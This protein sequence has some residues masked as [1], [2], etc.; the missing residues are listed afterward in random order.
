MFGMDKKVIRLIDAR[1]VIKKE[2]GEIVLRE[3]G[4][5]MGIGYVHGGY[6]SIKIK[7]DHPMF[8]SSVDSGACL[9]EHNYF[10]GEVQVGW[11]PRQ[12]NQRPK[13]Y[14]KNMS[15]YEKIRD[16]YVNSFE[17]LLPERYCRES[18]FEKALENRS[19]ISEWIRLWYNYTDIEYCRMNRLPIN[20]EADSQKIEMQADRIWEEL[21]KEGL[22]EG[23]ALINPQ[24]LFVIPSKSV[25][26][27]CYNKANNF[28]VKWIT[29]N[30]CVAD[31]RK[32][33]ISLIKA[34][35]REEE[36]FK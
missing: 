3:I 17:L 5:D 35:Y 34:C 30:A 16:K 24:Y 25:K 2:N 26:R 27:S 11:I 8:F 14:R 1:E 20:P 13:H 4:F 12:T 7:Y 32:D 22:T 9:F 31:N 36:T 6:T 29:P 18:L 23:N 10:L 19:K 33:F 15:D 28:G 21:S